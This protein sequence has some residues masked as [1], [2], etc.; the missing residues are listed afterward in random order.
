M[1]L[2]ITGWSAG[3]NLTLTTALR[4]IAEGKDVPQPR[5]LFALCPAVVM[6]QAV[7]QLPDD[8]RIYHHQLETY[9]DAATID[10]A[11][12]EACGGAIPFRTLCLPDF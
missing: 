9:A 10:K 11:T 4:I 3:G 2:F 6:S 8:L 12:V 5:A 1:K 7:D